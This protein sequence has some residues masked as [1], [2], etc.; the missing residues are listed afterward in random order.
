MCREWRSIHQ[1]TGRVRLHFVSSITVVSSGFGVTTAD[2]DL[3]G[4]A[5][6]RHHQI[7]DGVP[8]VLDARHRKSQ[9]RV[10]TCVAGM[11]SEA[12]VCADARLKGV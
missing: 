12:D 2:L 6:V 5:G 11:E 8:A 1:T 9:R 10:G 3:R 7:G 4:A